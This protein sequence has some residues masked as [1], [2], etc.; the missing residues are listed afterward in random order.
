MAKDKK[1]AR[2]D[3]KKVYEDLTYM[4]E[5]VLRAEPRGGGSNQSNEPD[6]PK[7]KP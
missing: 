1:T 4:G 2:R 3:E 7:P 6:E 5:E